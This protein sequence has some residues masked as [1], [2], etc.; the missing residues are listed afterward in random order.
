M[1]VSSTLEFT[2]EVLKTEKKYKSF[3][4]EIVETCAVCATRSV[5]KNK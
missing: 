2:E 4:G 5:T 1:P 3:V